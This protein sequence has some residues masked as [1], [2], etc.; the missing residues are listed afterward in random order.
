MGQ[1]RDLHIFAES[2]AAHDFLVRQW[3]N[4]AKR[5]IANRGRFT[6]A[7]SGGKTPSDFFRRLA[8]KDDLPWENTHIFQV[9]ERFVSSTDKES[10]MFLIRETLTS[11]APIPS[12]NIHPLTT[13]GITLEESATEYEEELRR[14]FHNENLPRFDLILLGI[15][16]NGH[17]ASLFP[18]SPSLHERHR[19]V[20]SVVAKVT[21]RKRI[22]LTLP[23]INNA[24]SAVFLVT[25]GRKA[26]V[27][28]EILED[29]DP[30]LPAAQVRPAK[31]SLVFVL[32]NRAASLLSQRTSD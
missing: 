30:S 15:G 25:G 2:T 3:D 4:V 5:A 20:V 22:S 18:G 26:P 21:P 7:L 1:K 13:E 29:N 6:V 11:G 14:F 27:M 9:D 16:D 12:E 10:N 23:V 32:D 8:V 17:S 28:R 31:G 19:L 24:R